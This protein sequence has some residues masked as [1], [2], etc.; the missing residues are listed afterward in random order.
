MAKLTDN[1]V[2]SKLSCQIFDE[3]AMLSEAFDVRNLLELSQ[4]VIVESDLCNFDVRQEDKSLG[5]EHVRQMATL[6]II[7]EKL[8]QKIRNF[9]KKRTFEQV[10]KGF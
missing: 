2:R 4:S 3:E 6:P 7:P 9:R 8:K 10:K 1:E 5:G